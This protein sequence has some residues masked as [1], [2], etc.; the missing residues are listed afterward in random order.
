MADGKARSQSLVQ[1][2]RSIFV[3]VGLSGS[4]DH[5][6]RLLVSRNSLSESRLRALLKL[7]MSRRLRR[8]LF[9]SAAL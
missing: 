7:P 9:L 8:L 1:K 5:I 3:R 6:K 2:K 4:F